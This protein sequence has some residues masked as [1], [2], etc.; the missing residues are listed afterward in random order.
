MA[1]EVVMPKLGMA[2]KEGIIT[3]WNIKA[4]DNVAKGELIASI[5]S[6]KIE[7]EI[8]APADG[9]GANSIHRRACWIWPYCS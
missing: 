1:V 9:D 2:M 4:G 5:N 6:E 8:E 3:N 7:T